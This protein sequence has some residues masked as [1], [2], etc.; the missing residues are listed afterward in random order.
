MRHTLIMKNQR[1]RVKEPDHSR[2]C[3][4]PKKSAVF[5]YRSTRR[6]AHYTIVCSTVR[7]EKFVLFF[8]V[9]V[10]RENDYFTGL[11][12]AFIMFQPWLQGFV[13]VRTA[14]PLTSVQTL[15]THDTLFCTIRFPGCRYQPSRELYT[16]WCLQNY[17]LLCYTFLVCT[18]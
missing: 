3:F 2:K 4:S 1:L 9:F 8:F 18:A 16:R 7:D 14:H 10:E 11:T 12:L 13:C 17:K 15:L 5:F 6:M